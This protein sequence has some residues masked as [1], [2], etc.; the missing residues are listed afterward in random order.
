MCDDVEFSRA[1]L[2]SKIASTN[3]VVMELDFT[4]VKKL[5]SNSRNK[6]EALSKPKTLKPYT[7][8][9]SKED[10]ELVSKAIIKYSILPLE[11]MENLPLEFVALML[12]TSPKALGCE[13]SIASYDIKIAETAKSNKKKLI[14]LETFDQQINFLRDTIN[15]TNKELVKVISEIEI[16]K[17]NMIELRRVYFEQNADKLFEISISEFKKDP[18][19]QAKILDERNKNWMPILEEKLKTKSIF[20]A[21]GAAHLGGENGLLK[22]LRDR[23]YIVEPIKL[24]KQIHQSKKSTRPMISFSSTKP[25]S[26]LSELSVGLS[27]SKE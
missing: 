4:D 25:N 6:S 24:K 11:I 14:G 27:P 17:K 1:V 10:R 8:T 2:A 23:G 5:V 22:L 21:V 13:K 9:L 18:K 26:L 3:E 19:F 15:V 20:I 7:E 16:S 12:R